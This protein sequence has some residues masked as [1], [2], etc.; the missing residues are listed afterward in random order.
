MTSI[1]ARPYGGLRFANPPYNTYQARTGRLAGLCLR[2]RRKEA[3]TCSTFGNLIAA[4]FVAMGRTI[5]QDFKPE[6]TR[7]R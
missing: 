4:M 6:T 5:Q 2:D 1:V 3:I 7:S